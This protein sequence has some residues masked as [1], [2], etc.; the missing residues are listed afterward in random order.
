MSNGGK[1]FTHKHKNTEISW[2]GEHW[3]PQSSAASSS[4]NRESLALGVRS[5]VSDVKK[6]SRAKLANLHQKVSNPDP[7][8]TKY[9]K[10]VRQAGTM[11]NDTKTDSTL[12]WGK[13]WS[14]AVFPEQVKEVNQ[15][16]VGLVKNAH[17]LG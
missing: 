4:C 2:T 6:N 10:S 15:G 9:G 11:I 16:G 14:C 17:Y 12:K 8:T 3:G 7:M 13:V 5:T 1:S